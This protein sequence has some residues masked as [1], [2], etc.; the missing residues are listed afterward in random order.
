[1]GEFSCLNTFLCGFFSIMF[2]I[3]LTVSTADLLNLFMPIS[4]FFL[5]NLVIS[6]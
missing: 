5:T 2:S 1:M 6:V 4:W 3:F